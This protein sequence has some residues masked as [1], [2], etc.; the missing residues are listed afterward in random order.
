MKTKKVHVES[1]HTVAFD[2]HQLHV[3]GEGCH[4]VIQLTDA[5]E[6]DKIKQGDAL[7]ISIASKAPKA[8]KAPKA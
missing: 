7:E 1:K 8:P 6:F 5:S 4:G 2:N 3:S